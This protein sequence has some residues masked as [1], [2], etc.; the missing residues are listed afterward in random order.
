M[1][2]G[3]GSR[4]PDTRIMIPMLYQLSYAGPT[5]IVAMRPELSNPASP[6]AWREFPVTSDQF[7]L[8]GFR[9]SDF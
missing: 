4:T 1:H 5:F 6:R 7:A 3:E 8:V 9:N 2:A